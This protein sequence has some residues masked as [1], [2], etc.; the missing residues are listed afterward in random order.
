MQPGQRW[1]DILEK[2][3]LLFQ[4]VKMAAEA[5]SCIIFYIYQHS[6]N[7]STYNKYLSYGICTC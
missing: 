2:K 1:S 6:W 7:I 5:S 3:M 4:G